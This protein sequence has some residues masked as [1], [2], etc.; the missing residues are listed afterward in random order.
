MIQLT[1]KL[2]AA[3]KLARREIPVSDFIPYACHYNDETLLTKN[4][5]LIQFLRLGG[6]PYET[7]DFDDIDLKKNLRNVLLRSVASDRY[8]LWFHTLR[9][10][11][12]AYPSGQFMPG[13]A[14][15]LNRSW[16]ERN[17]GSQLFENSLYISI[18]HR[19]QGGKFSGFKNILDSL[20][21][22]ADASE[23][24]VYYERGCQELTEVRRRFEAA[25]VDYRPHVLTV[26][27]TPSGCASEPQAFVSRLLNLEERVAPVSRMD[28]ARSLATKRLF[29]GPNAIEVRGAS[30][31][32][33]AAILSIK[34]YGAETAPGMLDAFFQLPFE[35][36]ITQ[37]FVFSH[38][39][40]AL[41]R[42]QRQQRLLGKSEDLAVSQVE[43]ITHA[44]DSAMSGEIAFGEHHLTVLPIA[45]TLPEL[46]E[47]VAAVESEFINLGIMAVREDLNLE[48]CFWAQL[49]GN[50]E[51][52]TRHAT[53]STANV[54]G[55]ASLHNIPSGRLDGNHWG[56]AV[57]VLETQSRTP[58]FFNFHSGDV[59]HTTVIG[60]TGAGK[61]VLLNFLCAQAQKFRCRLC[62]FDKD[63]GAEIFIRAIGGAYS[64]LGGG[65]ESG[66]NPLRLPDTSENRA[67]LTDWLQ[68]LVTTLG[69]AFTSKD[70]STISQAVSGVYKLQ[71][72]DR[73]LAKIAP[74]LGLP[75]PGTLAGR[76]AMW[77][78]DGSYRNIFGGEEDV[79]SLNRPVI[80]FEMG[81]ILHDRQ[82]LGPILLYLFHRI[83]LVLDG[84]P[85]MIV[86]DEAWALL[87]NPIFAPKIKDWLKTLRKLNAFVVFATQSVED[88]SKSAISDTLV[89]QSATQIY[90]PN[91]K[92][93]DAY[94][95]VFKLSEREVDWI[96]TL[97]PSSRAFLIKQGREAIV[98]RLNLL[99]MKSVIAVL[100]GRAETVARLDALRAK[101]G[102]DPASWLPIFME[103]Q[104]D[105]PVRK[106]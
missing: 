68:S 23:R 22:R 93:G 37:S 19:G 35:F 3:A 106:D 14:H 1:E 86:L 12:P 52:I 103:E 15:E 26:M 40:E 78:S 50:A 72:E 65:K 102:E 11:Q 48:P 16:K 89:Q 85:T 79:L 51:Y 74:F 66:F 45:R 92:A 34:E 42:M 43:E 90:F 20:S 39:Q 83:H 24:K 105:K 62:F 96:R 6:L 73:T 80:G 28:I 84:T 75:G 82:I 4:G 17:R 7:A 88:A 69:E 5:Q 95:T 8:A 33:L 18:V 31:S 10:R 60:P 64:I 101:V 30:S 94:R 76:L 91:A 56:P 49:P 63:R 98:A 32:K 13:F 54:A 100:S 36:V 53:I 104:H 99:G 71:P 77:H 27:R 70:Q 87:D 9:K 25:L 55:F 81:Q 97:E 67:F 2:P 29:F 46:N 61:T 58:F 21:H 38:R 41:G 57:T 44:L 47:A 59:G